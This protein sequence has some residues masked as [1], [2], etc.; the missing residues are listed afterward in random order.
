ENRLNHIPLNRFAEADDIAKAA[1]FLASDLSSYMT[2]A[3]LVVDGG[4][5]AAYLTKGP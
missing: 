5:T 1:L 4:I 2:G 3:S